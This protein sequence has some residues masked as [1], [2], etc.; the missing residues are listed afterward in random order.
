M[1][2]VD[3]AEHFLPTF[4]HY[5]SPFARHPRDPINYETS[6]IIALLQLSSV[7]PLGSLCSTPATEIGERR[8]S[9]SMPGSQRRVGSERSTASLDTATGRIRCPESRFP[10]DSTPATPSHD[11][12]YAAAGNTSA[13]PSPDSRAG[14]LQP[15]LVHVFCLLIDL[16]NRLHTV[17][18][19]RRCVSSLT[20]LMLSFSW[21]SIAGLRSEI[22]MSVYWCHP[23]ACFTSD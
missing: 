6:P 3:S 21:Y 1:H 5:A 13:I 18:R 2:P 16:L 12:D 4:F 22:P 9:T 20:N 19:H 15:P 10:T 8:L 11:Y 23:T 17:A 14:S 7:R